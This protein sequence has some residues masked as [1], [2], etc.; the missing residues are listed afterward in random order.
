MN[1]KK[2]KEYNEYINKEFEILKGHFERCMLRCL[3]KQSEIFSESKSKAS[4]EKQ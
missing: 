3:N 1:E 2:L 4:R